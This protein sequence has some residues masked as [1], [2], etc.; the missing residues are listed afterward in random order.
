MPGKDD[1]FKKN[2]IN[3]MPNIGNPSPP[4]QLNYQNVTINQSL[5]RLLKQLIDNQ[6]K[7]DMY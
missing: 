3:S 5:E 2:N 1:S 6:Q 4:P 7:I